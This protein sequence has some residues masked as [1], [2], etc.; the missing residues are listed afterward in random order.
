MVFCPG[1]SHMSKVFQGGGRHRIS[2]IVG[3]GRRCRC[4]RHDVVAAL[5]KMVRGSRHADTGLSSGLNVLLGPGWWLTMAVASS[6]GHGRD[7]LFL[8]AARRSVFCVALCCSFCLWR[9]FCFCNSVLFVF[10]LFLFCSA[11]FSSV[12]SRGSFFLHCGALSF[13]STWHSVFCVAS[14]CSFFL[15]CGSLFLHRVALLC[16]CAAQCSFFCSTALFLFVLHHALFLFAAR[17][18]CFCNAALFVFV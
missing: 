14:C 9:A 10:C 18:F 15:C 2:V 17:D 8:F 13:C 16:L 1:V 11:V 5:G 4:H 3:Q 6:L 7:P 12:T